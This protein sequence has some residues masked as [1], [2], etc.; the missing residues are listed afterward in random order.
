[1]VGQT[2]GHYKILDLLGAGGMTLER[3]VDIAIPLADAFSGLSQE[4]EDPSQAST[5]AIGFRPT[6]MPP[7]IAKTS[8]PSVKSN[9][10]RASA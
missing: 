6:V 7:P 9:P 4:G 1:M 3:I 10:C 2:L 8:G 5:P